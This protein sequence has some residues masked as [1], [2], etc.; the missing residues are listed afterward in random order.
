MSKLRRSML[1]LPGNSPNMVQDAH[2][3]GSDSILID[4]EDSVV[5]SEKD[6]ARNLVRNALDNIDYGDIEVT[7][8]INPV[9]TDFYE[10]DLKAI[11]P[12][13]PDA[14]RVPKSESAEQIIKVDEFI[15][16]LEKENNIE[17]GSTK[18]MPMIESA[19][20]VREVN[21]IAQASSRN[22]ALTIGGE[23]LATDLG[24]TRTKGS[25]EI[26]TS[27]SLI[28][29]AAKAAGID[30][31]D[32]I[33]SNVNDIE[34]LKRETE[35][36]KKLGFSGKAVIHPKQIKPVHEVFNPKE[37]EVREARKIIDAAEEAE[38]KG[39]GAIIVNGK[40]IDYPI[41]DRA[42]RTVAYAE[43]TSK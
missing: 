2:L 30:A 31:L 18:L 26:F 5:I 4:L 21:E 12:G 8:R 36:I 14:I 17:V 19:K 27:R 16:E 39:Q 13:K 24:V 37:E 25:E 38:R 20:G 42:K 43:S 9:H 32:T 7:I 22:V 10:D 11:I 6:A 41:V 1:Y 33:Y 34:G 15:T 35:L 3:Y 23:D 28:V 29:L 40:M